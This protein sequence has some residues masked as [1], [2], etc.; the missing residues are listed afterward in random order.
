MSFYI[1]S[2]SVDILAQIKED[3]QNYP[4]GILPPGKTM[5][6]LID[7]T[8]I[9]ISDTPLDKPQIEALQKGLT[10]C[11]TPGPPQKSLIWKDFKSFHRRLV[12]QHHFY[13]DNNILDNDDR[14]LVSIFA[15]N[16]DDNINP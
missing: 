2:D 16:L 14:E 5:D 7:H 12:L 3:S 1:M 9:N 13:Q 4:P 15:S 8:V 6:S 10:F 11:P